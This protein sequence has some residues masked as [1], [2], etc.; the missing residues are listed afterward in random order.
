MSAQKTAKVPVE[1]VRVKPKTCD[2][3]LWCILIHCPS[4]KR[5][6]EL[7]STQE[8]LARLSSFLSKNFGDGKTG[9]GFFTKLHGRTKRTKH[10]DLHKGSANVKIVKGGGLSEAAARELE[11]NGFSFLAALSRVFVKTDN[12]HVRILFY[13]LLCGIILHQDFSSSKKREWFLS[14]CKMG[15]LYVRTKDP[16]NGSEE[17]EIDVNGAF[18]IFSASIMGKTTPSMQE[19]TFEIY[20]G[21]KVNMLG[22]GRGVGPET[23]RIVIRGLFET[24]DEKIDETY[25]REKAILIEEEAARQLRRAVQKKNETCTCFFCLFVCVCLSVCLCSPFFFCGEET[26]PRNVRQ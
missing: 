18:A 15:K 21:T 22:D 26:K 10:I 6:L 7:A 25:I 23:R 4:L 16:K 19:E 1:I 14:L 17:L 5:I 24:K 8:N 3:N 12:R 2:G 20:H 13:D 11:E 9:R